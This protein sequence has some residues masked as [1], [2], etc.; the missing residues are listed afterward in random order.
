MCTHD[1]RIDWGIATDKTPLAGS[2]LIEPGHDEMRP[3]LDRR[4]TEL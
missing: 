1:C 2:K 3:K 4:A